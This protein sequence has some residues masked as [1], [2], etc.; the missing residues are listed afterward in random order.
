MESGNAFIDRDNIDSARI[1][2]VFK[3]AIFVENDAYELQK[4]EYGKVDPVHRKYFEL[5]C[6]TQQNLNDLANNENRWCTE[7]LTRLFH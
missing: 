2:D 1:K 4:A 7:D 5:A 6:E 3:Y